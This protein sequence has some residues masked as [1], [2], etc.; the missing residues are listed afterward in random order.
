MVLYSMPLPIIYCFYFLFYFS[1]NLPPTSH[2]LEYKLN[3]GR[4]F[5]WVQQCVTKILRTMPDS[6]KVFNNYLL[7]GW[8]RYWTEI[9][10]TWALELA[11]SPLGFANNFTDEGTVLRGEVTYLGAW[12]STWVAWPSPTPSTASLTF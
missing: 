8:K 3:E 6:W 9:Q 11:L 12:V 1:R 7:D 4:G 10:V 2:Q 5:L